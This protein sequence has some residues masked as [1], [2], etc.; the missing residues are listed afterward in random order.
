MNQDKMIEALAKRMAFTA[1][2]RNDAS[3]NATEF[4]VYTGDAAKDKWMKV[5]ATVLE[6]MRPKRLAWQR[7][8]AVSANGTK[9]IV[10]ETDFDDGAGEIWYIYVHGKA[11]GKLGQ[12]NSD[13][14][15]QA[16]AQAH[17]DAQWSESLP[18]GELLGVKP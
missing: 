7:G 14:S 2:E 12:H 13:H 6:L 4:W 9:Y 8:A 17:A 15:A 11:A 18:L 10:A 5:A 1:K 3:E 16:A